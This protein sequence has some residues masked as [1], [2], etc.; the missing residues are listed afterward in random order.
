MVHF[1]DGITSLMQ[2]SVFFL[3]GL[4]AFPSMMVDILV[5]AIL[6]A[7]FLTFISRPLAVSLLLKPQG[8]SNRQIALVSWS[9]LRGA[10]SIVFAIMATVSPAYLKNDLFHIVFCVVLLSIAVQG[11]LLPLVA[12]KLGMVDPTADALRSFND[13]QEVQDVQ[14]VRLRIS[15]NHPWLG[16]QLRELTL[17]PDMLIV[18]IQH[19]GKVVIP[20]GAD[21]LHLGD[22]LVITAPAFHDNQKIDLRETI[23]PS[24]HEWCERALRE[25][26]LPHGVLVV[27]TKHEGIVTV[28]HGDTVL[29]AGDTVVMTEVHV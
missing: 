24:D 7:L 28:P 25:I 15:E 27:L 6:I 17:P 4:L 14:F 3:L 16:K 19:G 11:T 23:L 5:P 2:M 21:T 18:S 10:S 26:E 8:C 29:Y 22:R 13:Y 12:H 20:H 1:F 9:G